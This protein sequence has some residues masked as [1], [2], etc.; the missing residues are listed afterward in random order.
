MRN[1]LTRSQR[2]DVGG[3]GVHE[4]DRISTEGRDAVQT[5]LQEI[6]RVPLLNAEQERHLARRVQDG[7]DD[8]KAELASANLRLV[9]SIAKRYSHFGLPL[10]DLVQE[11]SL[12][13]MRA[14]EK[15]DPE[16]GYKFS[17]YATWWIRQS[18]TRAITQTSRAIRLPESLVQRLRQLHQAEAAWMDAHGEMPS[19]DDLAQEL[20]IPVDQVHQARQ[21]P[22]NLT[23]LDMPFDDDSGDEL[24]QLIEDDKSTTPLRTALQALQRDELAKAFRTLTERERH[25]LELRYG[26]NGHEPHTLEGAGLAFDLSRERIRQIQNEGLEKLRHPRIRRRL[27]QFLH[28][29]LD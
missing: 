7:D 10:L 12:G 13:L 4:E 18:I 14:T 19:D 17:T 16:R 1:G 9:V 21:A 11:G 20:G 5:Y 28:L 26:L 25:V 15:F 27:E 3:D 8:A 22:Q 6:G 2:G 24:G 23:S 29:S